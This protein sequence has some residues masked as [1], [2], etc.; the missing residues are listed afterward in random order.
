MRLRSCTTS[1]LPL[2]HVICKHHRPTAPMTLSPFSRSSTEHIAFWVE[3]DG[4]IP[5]RH[6]K[7]LRKY[8]AVKSL[9]M[10]HD[11]TG[12]LVMQRT[13][14][15]GVPMFPLRLW[16]I[17]L[18][19]ITLQGNSTDWLV[20]ECVTRCNA[21]KSLHWWLRVFKVVVKTAIK[22]LIAENF[23][24]QRFAMCALSGSHIIVG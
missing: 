13:F 17:I 1:F 10:T 3:A 20:C 24:W 18:S 21:E 12:K 2:I 6:T 9:C 15:G 8:Y 7:W 14:F 11:E 22:W 4:K 16:M 5:W 23:P 19:S